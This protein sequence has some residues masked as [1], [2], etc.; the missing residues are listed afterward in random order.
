MFVKSTKSSVDNGCSL[1]DPS[2]LSRVHSPCTL[3][4]TSGGNS[5]VLSLY[6]RPANNNHDTRDC[7]AMTMELM[8]YRLRGPTTPYNCFTTT[9]AR[10][11]RCPIETRPRTLRKIVAEPIFSR[12]MCM[13][14]CTHICV[15]LHALCVSSYSFQQRERTNKRA[16]RRERIDMSEFAKK[17]V[18]DLLRLFLKMRHVFIFSNKSN[19][20][21]L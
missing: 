13:Y 4:R 16:N 9:G 7:P 14:I 2:P 6:T 19:G 10:Q 12:D 8:K 17:R 15:C 1:S 5:R 11:R 21:V 18:R 3:F 20:F